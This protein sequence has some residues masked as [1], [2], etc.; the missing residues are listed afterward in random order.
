MLTSDSLLLLLSQLEGGRLA[1]WDSLFNAGR[2]DMSDCVE[3][4][5]DLA[6]IILGSGRGGGEFIGTDSAEIKINT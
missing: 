4:D 1:N 5:L 2:E 3:L 6:E